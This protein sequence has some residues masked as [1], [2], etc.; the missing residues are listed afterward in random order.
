ME[1]QRPN[2]GDCLSSRAGGTRG[3]HPGERGVIDELG[4][5]MHDRD[6]ICRGAGRTSRHKGKPARKTLS[7]Q[8]SQGQ[9]GV[10]FCQSI[11]W[12]WWEEKARK[13]DWDLVHVRLD[14]TYEVDLGG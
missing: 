6:W 5:D 3:A 9:R 4:R 10:E 8:A 2:P 11:K 7:L 1:E 13:V 14:A 12:S